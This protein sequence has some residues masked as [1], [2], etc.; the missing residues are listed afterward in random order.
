MKRFAIFAL[1]MGLLALPLYAQT[2]PTGTLT[3]HVTDGKEA[4]PAV[5]ITITSPALMG[6]RVTMTQTSGDYIFRFVPPGEYHV[7]FELQ[8]FQTLDTTIRISAAQESKLDAE[9]PAAK[10][11]E[12][13]TVTGSY[14]TI[15]ATATSASTYE[16]KLV[17]TLPV[18]RDVVNYVALSPGTSATGPNQNTVIG[19]AMSFENLYLVN[20]VTV[21]EN[22][23]GQYTPVYIEDGIQETTTSLSNVS[24]EFGRFTGG[25]VNTLTK[26]GG[27]EFH[28]SLRLNLSNPKWTAATP[29]TTSRND[30]LGKIW[31]ATLGGY[32]F[33]DKLW[34]FVAG[35]D[36]TTDAQNQLYTPVNEAF[37]TTTKETRYEGKLTWSITPDHRII[38]SYAKRTRDWT[39]YFFPSYPIYDYASTYPRSIPEDLY[40]ANYT[41]VLSNNFF[42][43]AQYSARHLTFVGSGGR[44]TDFINGTPV[45]GPPVSPYPI[46]NSPIFCGV[47]QAGDEKRDNEDY[48]AKGSWFLSTAKGGSHDL[49]FGVDVYSDMRTSNNYQSGSSYFIDP[50]DVLNDNNGINTKFY[51]VLIG[52][53]EYS[54]IE[55]WPIFVLSQGNDFKTQSAFV[56]DV[57]RLNNNWSF[58]IGVRYDKNHGVDANGA[59]VVNDSKFSPRLSVTWDPKG[60]GDMNVSLGYG[61]YVAAIANS[62]ADSQASGG[63]P[64]YYNIFYGGPDINANCDPTTGVGCTDTHAALQIIKDWLDS[65]GGILNVANQDQWGP[66]GPS[67]PGYDTYIGN[68]VSPSTTEWALSFNKR[69]GTR[70]LFRFDYINRKWTNFYDSVLNTT[71]GTTTDPLGLEYNNTIITNNTSTLSREYQGYLLNANY[72]LT[73]TLQI[74]GNYTMSFLK[75]NVVGETSGSGPVTTGISSYPEYHQNSWFAPKG[76]LSADQRHKLNLFV[77]WDAINTRAFT[78]NISVL[79]RYLSGT[80]Y[81]ATSNY[82]R[83]SN[84]VTNP[85]YISPPS[86]STYYFTSRDAYRTDAQMPT[87]LAMTFTFKVVGLELWLNARATNVFNEE[88]VIIPNTTVYTAYNG[89]GLSRFDPFT[90]AP[91]ECPQGST[92]AQCTA[93]GANWMK[94]NSFG[95]ATAPSN[96]ETPRT[97]LLALGIRF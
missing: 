15:S 31:E 90:T 82:V 29:L 24:A 22:I 49:R 50:E 60:D 79:Q 6:P 2:V 84:Y 13:V 75:G 58:N 45:W 11:A 47:C 88:K 62:I 65:I 42:V 72:R 73:D 77:S 35:R 69:L 83:V 37:V 74:G 4:L 25:V 63:Q 23:R 54:Y 21:N 70:G 1:L 53:N 78:W 7:K 97:Y 8:G 51:P 66:Y 64:A 96:Y 41:G 32:V 40:S 20:G 86:Y 12:E 10:V 46:Y 34:F 43:E 9:M 30:V 76:Y 61:E 39:N 71:T 94:G 52:G 55:Y 68:L 87:D 57:W 48:I 14:E 80:P 89:R 44:Y 28:G 16:S 92:S 36:T 95:K 67:V 93:L 26:S 59:L 85:G 18:G 19:G 33:T 3:G 27:N 91:I 5:T 56:N 38:G 17:N 81:G